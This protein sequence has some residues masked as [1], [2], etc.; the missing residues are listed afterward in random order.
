MTF[1]IKES[2]LD[3]HMWNDLALQG[4]FVFVI[5]WIVFLGLLG[6]L[7][8]EIRLLIELHKDLRE[9]KKDRQD[10]ERRKNGDKPS[11]NSKGFSKFLKFL[12]RFFVLLRKKYEKHRVF[13]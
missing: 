6:L 2:L 1:I 8:G 11:E 3:F 13:N 5:G 9:Y 4:K 7:Y 12:S 10:Q